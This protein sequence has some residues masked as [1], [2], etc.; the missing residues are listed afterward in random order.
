MSRKEL[1]KK[2][3][4][5][6][7][8]P[9][10]TGKTTW[11]SKQ[12][13]N[14]VQKYGSGAVLVA[15]FTTSA[16][17]EIAGRGLPITRDQVGT[18]HAHCYRNL[19]RPDLIYKHKEDWNKFAP[20][21]QL[22]RPSGFDLDDPNADMM[23]GQSKGDELLRQVQ[24][25]RAKM[26]DEKLWPNLARSFYNKWCEFKDEYNCI[27]FTDMIELNI[28][29]DLEPPGDPYIGFY[30]EA[31]D[32][33][34]LELTLVRQWSAYMDRIIIVGDDDQNLYS[35]KGATPEAFLKPEIPDDQVIILDQS[36][37]VPRLVQEKA[38]KWIEQIP[39][40]NRK[41]KEYKPRDYEGELRWL[42]KGSYKYTKP[43]IYDSQKYLDE[44]K[45]V[46][47][48]TTCGYMLK[49]LIERLKFRGMPFHNPYTKR[50]AD[51]NP[52]ATS[53]VSAKDQIMSF[54]RPRND[55]FGE[56]ARLWTYRDLYNWTR[57]IKAK[58]ILQ[59]GA[60]SSIENTRG[61]IEAGNREDHE[62][63]VDRLLEFF[64]EEKLSKIMECNLEWLEDNLLAS[65]KNRN[66]IQFVFNIIDRFGIEALLEEPS[67]KIGTI[68]SVKGGEADVVY[69]FPDL[70]LSG[71]QE[72]HDEKRKDA[73]IR[74]F[75]VGM[76]RARESLIICQ[77]SGGHSVRL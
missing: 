76:T 33:T 63:E 3:E 61:E 12:V 24:V 60:K 20:Q 29:R 51:W 40:E 54:L 11:L 8:G 14:A 50:R 18:L 23:A 65:Q 27:D 15:S 35:F 70:S 21:Y 17:A 2:K 52:L 31:Q 37:R 66:T 57:L 5:R 69:L 62:V 55:I 38:Q 59:H 68:H 73:I 72:W 1:I 56:D 41:K 75:Y 36:Y 42:S 47:F 49:D 13:K 7:F 67:I 16:S 39:A 46:M 34:P 58:G 22:S 10:G 4:W 6:C 53:G 74:Q 32:F 77:P 9:P 26:I 64:E 44:G 48:L 71:M 25:L 30:D 28:E 43:I 45:T 19:G